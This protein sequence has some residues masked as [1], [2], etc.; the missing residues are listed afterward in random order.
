MIYSRLTNRED[1]PATALKWLGSP[2]QTPEGKSP[3]GGKNRPPSLYC[4]AIAIARDSQ[5]S[6]ER[7]DPWRFG[8]SISSCLE[9]ILPLRI[10]LT[11]G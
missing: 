10:K 11:P 5:C 4:V 6:G 8:D 7:D 2:C 1:L 9:R 3:R